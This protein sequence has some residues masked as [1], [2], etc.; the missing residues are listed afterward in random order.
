MAQY[1]VLEE[2]GVLTRE[3]LDNCGKP[4]GELGMHP[5]YG[6]P[7]IEA[8]TGSLGHGLPLSLG[9]ALA[10]KVLGI[11]RVVYVVMSDGELQEGSNWEALL[12]A[13]SLGLTNIVAIVDLNDSV[14]LGNIS[15]IHPNFY[16]LL[17]KVEAFGWEGVEVDGHDQQA[18]VDAVASRSGLKP[19]LIIAKTTKGKGISYME[20]EPIWHYRKPSPEEYQ[21]ALRELAEH[22]E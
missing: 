5:D 11:D 13:P 14:S 6:L 12:L 21:I 4:T 18:I 9:L 22:R 16:P 19:S 10:D 7:G 2:L 3:E 17:D 8:S 20:N 1:A 15:S